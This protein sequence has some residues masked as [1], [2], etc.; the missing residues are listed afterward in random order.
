MASKTIESRRQVFVSSDELVEIYSSEVKDP[1]S[2]DVL[3]TSVSD[4]RLL[5]EKLI[6]GWKAHIDIVDAQPIPLSRQDVEKEI[7]DAKRS[8]GETEAILGRVFAFYFAVEQFPSKEVPGA[9]TVTLDRCLA[10]AKAMDAK[11]CARKLFYLMEV[12]EL[13]FR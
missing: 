12:S 3:I 2:R 8:I 5:A 6:S 13:T 9:M 10:D 7:Q 1:V 11:L 4:V